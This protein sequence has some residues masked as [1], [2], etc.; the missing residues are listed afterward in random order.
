RSGARVVR[1]A[2]SGNLACDW[3]DACGHRERTAPAEAR[4][5]GP[6]RRGRSLGDGRHLRTG[7][8]SLMRILIANEALAGGGGVETYLAAL[9]PGLQAAG[10]EVGVLHDNP[11]SDAGPQRIA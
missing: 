2:A 10:H 8:A 11:G 4:R 5:R 7:A 9:V 1:G 3:R 6:P